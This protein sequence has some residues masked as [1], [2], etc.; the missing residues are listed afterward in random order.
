M[1]L[2][3]HARIPYFKARTDWPSQV[4]EEE[5]ATLKLNYLKCIRR[6]DLTGKDEPRIKVHGTAVWNGVVEKGGKVTIDWQGDFKDQVSVICEEMNDDKPQQIGAAVNVFETGNPAFLTFKTSGTWYEV[7]FEVTPS[8]EAAQ[9][10]RQH[11]PA[12]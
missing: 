5:M 8:T 3:Q 11:A 1:H 2:L 6:N 4:K 10:A 12:G 9:T 7:Y